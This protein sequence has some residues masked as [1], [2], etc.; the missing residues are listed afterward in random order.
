MKKVVTIQSN[1]HQHWVGDGFH[2]RSIFSYNDLSKE[3]SPFLLMDYGGHTE[4]P[5]TKKR[6]GVGEHPHRGFETVTIVYDGEVEHRD[7]SGGGGLIRKGDV[8][9]MTAG[10]G[11][12]HEEFHGT[13]YAKKGGPFEM[14]QLWVNLPKKNKMTAP[15][16]QAITKDVIPEFPLA[17]GAGLVRVIAGHFNGTKG[18]A[19]TFSAVNLWDI[20]AHFEK[21]VELEVPPGFT[22]AVFVLKGEIKFS[23]KNVKG[24][25]MAILER[26][27]QKLSFEVLENARV[28]LLNG[29]PI[30]E[31]VV[32]YGPFVM[33]SEGEIRQ[34]M[35][36]YESGRMG[37]L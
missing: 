10:S 4:F 5:P 12:V 17:N 6:L 2:V 27:G 34:A 13:D 22:T 16:Y 18:P 36:D 31:P 29:E 37:H 7:S 24:G 3:M 23:D 19:H 33:N 9:W 21:T 1:P 28:L 26:D 14:I 25:E 20:T 30:N 8:Q 11:I 15:G 32:G 35:I